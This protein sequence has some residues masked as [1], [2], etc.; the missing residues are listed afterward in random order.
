MG[1][2]MLSIDSLKKQLN[3][4]E[5]ELSKIEAGKMPFDPVGGMYWKNLKVS[6]C[7]IRNQISF[8]A[9]ENN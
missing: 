4:D 2:K 1:F 9:Q 7:N 8:M 5:S 6:I 3:Y